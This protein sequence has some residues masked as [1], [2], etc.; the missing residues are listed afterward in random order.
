MD[1]EAH[2]WLS[3]R[4]LMLDSKTFSMY[5]FTPFRKSQLMRLQKYLTDVLLDQIPPL[6]DLKYW[7]AQAAFSDPPV[8]KK[9]LIIELVP[10]VRIPK[11]ISILA[12]PFF[13]I[14]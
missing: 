5:E 4:Q 11:S 7:L 8:Q 3:L 13:S 10:E 6:M 2:V 14:F 9:S 1:H 12:P